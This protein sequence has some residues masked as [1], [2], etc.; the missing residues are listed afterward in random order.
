MSQ[1]TLQLTRHE[2]VGLES[3]GTIEHILS[4]PVAPVLFFP[5]QRA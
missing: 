1:F 4:R 2:R 3:F 5:W